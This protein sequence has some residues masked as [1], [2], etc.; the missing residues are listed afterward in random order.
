M[1]GKTIRQKARCRCGFSTHSDDK[2]S[3]HLKKYEGAPT[4]HRDEVHE[5]SQKRYNRS[6]KIG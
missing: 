4:G 5:L 6:V 1:P 2:M 3:V